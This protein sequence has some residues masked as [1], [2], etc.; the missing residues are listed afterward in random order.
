MLLTMERALSAL[1]HFRKIPFLENIRKTA[2][3]K[4]EARLS[5]EFTDSI[6]HEKGL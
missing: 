1:D 2:L 5:V 4:L 3:V 6:S